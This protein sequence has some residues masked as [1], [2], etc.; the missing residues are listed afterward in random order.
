M[1]WR[2]RWLAVQ[3]HCGL[4]IDRPDQISVSMGRQSSVGAYAVN[5]PSL[6]FGLI[7]IATPFQM[8]GST[9]GYRTLVYGGTTASLDNQTLWCKGYGCNAYPD[10]N[11]LEACTGFGTLR[12]AMLTGKPGRWD[13]FKASTRPVR[14]GAWPISRLT[15]TRTAPR[16][17]MSPRFTRPGR[18]PAV[19]CARTIRGTDRTLGIRHA[20]SSS[21]RRTVAGDRV[22]L[23]T[24]APCGLR[25]LRAATTCCGRCHD[26]LWA[27]PRLAVGA[28]TTCCGRCHDLL[29]APPRSCP[30][31]FS[32]SSSNSATAALTAAAAASSSVSGCRWCRCPGPPGVL[33]EAARGWDTPLSRSPTQTGE[34]QVSASRRPGARRGVS[35]RACRPWRRPASA[36]RPR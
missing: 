21:A 4:D 23:M 28:A 1:R 26:L 5:H 35:D 10:P 3:A 22:S 36:C 6:D 29:W 20:A 15:S 14:R 18:P 27:L 16:P 17:A 31:A 32:W 24:V 7:R 19:T 2:R 13:D 9:T 34:F 8:N 25:L 12:Q 33:N 30:R 11:N